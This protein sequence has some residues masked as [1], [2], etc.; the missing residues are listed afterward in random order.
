M[1]VRPDERRKQTEKGRDSRGCPYLFYVLIGYAVTFYSVWVLWELFGRSLVDRMVPGEMMAQLIKSGVVKNLVWTVPAL[2][3]IE[4]FKSDVSIT[5]KEMFSIRVKWLNYLP[6][7]GIF[8]FY[9]LI[10]S[11][12]KN[13]SAQIVNSFG[14][15]KIVIVLFV[16]LTEEMV[17]R[18]WLLNATVCE[19]KKWLYISLNAAMFLAIHFP[20]WA[21]TGTFITNFTSFGFLE[22][23]AL[24]VVFSCTFLKSRS[25]FVPIVLHMYWDLLVFLL[26]G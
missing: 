7:F 19:E 6:I 1:I 21:Y 3:L 24:S 16:G 5:L 8:T 9:M 14:P 26:I 25:I 18:G 4:R 13:G 22:I 17:F 10:G 11:V 23:L 20:I 12:L 15:E 2:L